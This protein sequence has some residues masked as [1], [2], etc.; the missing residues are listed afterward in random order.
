MMT[1]RILAQD[2]DKKYLMY[3][4]LKYNISCTVRVQILVGT[5]RKSYLIY[6]YVLWVWKNN[7]LG[8]EK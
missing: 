4:R 8:V 3:F 2:I 5:N 7:I 1:H 6:D